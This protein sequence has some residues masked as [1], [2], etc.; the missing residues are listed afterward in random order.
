M[1][2][3]I[4]LLLWTT[5]SRPCVVFQR[6]LEMS[7]R[8]KSGRDIN[9]YSCL[10]PRPAENLL[11]DV[12]GRK[13]RALVLSWKLHAYQINFAEPPRDASAQARSQ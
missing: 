13:R 10:L 1:G 12:L 3:V 8:R 5:V 11:L 7:G 9:T 2:S 4:L 6:L